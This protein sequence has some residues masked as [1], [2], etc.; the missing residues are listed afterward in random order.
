[1]QSI[2][3]DGKPLISV[4]IV[5]Y[6]RKAQVIECIDSVLKSTY[7]PLEIIVVDNA[8]T[9][10]TAGELEYRYPKQIKLIKSDK[11]IYAGGGRNLGAKSASGEYLLFVDSDNVIDVDMIENLM[12][13]SLDEKNLKIGMSGPFTYYKSAPNRLCWVNNRMSLLTSATFFFGT[14]QIDNGQYDKFDFIK[15]QHIPNVFMVRKDIY[16]LVGGIDHEYVM[17]YEESDLAQKIK[18]QGYD[19]VLVPAAKTWHDVVLERQKGHKSFKGENPSMVYYVIRNRIYFMRKNSSGWR[20]FLFLVMF[21]N[22][23]L[24]YHLCVLIFNRQFSLLR[25]ALKGYWDG[26]F[27]PLTIR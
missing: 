24:L 11:N 22:L 8:S 18:K 4:I 6:N 16:E 13:L 2:S 9:D 3:L 20:L 12:K 15:V 21:N 1:M 19:I 10:G 25:L 17:H 7:R 14:G 5:T 23:F 26:I 27:S